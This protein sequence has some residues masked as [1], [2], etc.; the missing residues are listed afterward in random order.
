[1]D[2]KEE[3]KCTAA[4]EMN[5]LKKNKSAKNRIQIKKKNVVK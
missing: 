3:M 5:F 4:R 1:M 2:Q